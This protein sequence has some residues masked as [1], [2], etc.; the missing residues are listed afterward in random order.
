[1][2]RHSSHLVVKASETPGFARMLLARP[3]SQE[4]SLDTC[5]MWEAMCLA[6]PGHT[7]TLF[8]GTRAFSFCLRAARGSVCARVDSSHGKGA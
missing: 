4:P 8:G 7:H 6:A 2:T 1:M 3:T 5:L